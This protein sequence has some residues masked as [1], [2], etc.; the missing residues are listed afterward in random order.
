[1]RVG[2]LSARP[3]SPGST[4]KFYF[5]IIDLESLIEI[6][7]IKIENSINC[8]FNFFDFKFFT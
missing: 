6:C 4:K 1:M 5:S 7:S 2:G 3:P 8:I